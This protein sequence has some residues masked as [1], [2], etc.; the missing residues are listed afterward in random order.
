MKMMVTAAVAN[1]HVNSSDRWYQKFIDYNDNK[2]D[3]SGG[4]SDSGQWRVEKMEA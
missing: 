3:R 1:D 2:G 4:N